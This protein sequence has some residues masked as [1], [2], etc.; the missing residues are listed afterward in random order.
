MPL[1]FVCH[2]LAEA[3][4]EELAA[5]ITVNLIIIEFS[6][7]FEIR[8]LCRISSRSPSHEQATSRALS[9]LMPHSSRTNFGLRLVYRVGL[10]F[11]FIFVEIVLHVA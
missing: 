4:G 11:V 10:G 5:R 9:C 3:G 8:R 6:I 2:F 1:K 7:P